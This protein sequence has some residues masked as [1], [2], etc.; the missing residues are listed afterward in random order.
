[1]RIT[2]RGEK[3][4]LTF[5]SFD[6]WHVQMTLGDWIKRCCLKNSEIE[7][8]IAKSCRMGKPRGFGGNFLKLLG[9]KDGGWR[10]V[11]S[12]LQDSVTET[13]EKNRISLSGHVSCP[14]FF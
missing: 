6:V 12:N 10:I 4:M 8:S 5:C 2:Y 11:L 7:G 1:M 14:C 13:L 9:C 3:K